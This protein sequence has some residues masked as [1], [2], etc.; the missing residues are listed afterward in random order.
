MQ[1]LVYGNMYYV[2]S[3]VLCCVMSYT[4]IVCNRWSNIYLLRNSL[5]LF[6]IAFVHRIISHERCAVK[7]KRECYFISLIT[8]IGNT[9]LISYKIRF[10]I[11]HTVNT[12]LFRFFSFRFF[13]LPAEISIPGYFASYLSIPYSLGW[14]R[15]WSKKL[16]E[17]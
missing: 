6:H 2:V 8:S 12:G 5:T 11:K 14:G 16:E 7:I 15:E 10:V 17:E 3:V 4:F 9:A 1:S 13:F